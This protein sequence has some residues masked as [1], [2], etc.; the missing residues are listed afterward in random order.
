MDLGN[1]H[2]EQ[3]IEFKR[4]AN[5][6]KDNDY[7]FLQETSSPEVGSIIEALSRHD[8]ANPST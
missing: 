2:F 1:V 4:L 7:I 6:K 3:G 8:S 5:D